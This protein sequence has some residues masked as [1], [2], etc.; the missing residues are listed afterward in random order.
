MLDAMGFRAPD[1]VQ[2]STQLH[3]PRVGIKPSP[4]EHFS[5]LE[6]EVCNCLSVLYNLSR[7]AGIFQNV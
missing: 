3:K 2:K 6:G 1:I 7:T 4:S 5:Y